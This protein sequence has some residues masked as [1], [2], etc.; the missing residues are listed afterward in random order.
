V[1]NLAFDQRGY[2]AFLYGQMSEFMTAN[3]PRLLLNT[4]VTNISYTNTGVT[5]YSKDGDCIEA[6]YAITTF[7]V[8]V[9]QSGDVSFEPELP[10]WKKIAINT[11]Q[12]GTYTKIY[13][14]FRPEDVFWNATTE[15]FLYASKQRG[16]YPLWQSLDHQNFLS[17][18]GIIFV[19]VVT[20]QSY[21]VDH[22]DDETT[23]QQVLAVLRAMFG[24]DRVPEPIAFMYPRW[25]TTPWAYGSYSNWPP[26]M[27]LENHQN[28]RAN[29]GP[30]YFAGEA[31][32]V[33]FYGYLHGAYFEGKVVGEQ[34]AACITRNC[35]PSVFYETLHGSTAT[36][37]YNFANGWLQADI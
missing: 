25:S 20:E 32:S 33:E 37:Q 3:D 36:E 34:V 10:I 17:R 23:K 7:S 9:L 19:T 14:Q 13:L 26:G 22:Q 8:G 15:L 35:T 1:N 31:T 16:Y 4:I 18:S 6:D 21:V 30:V 5:V 12:M 28:L 2:N 24:N 11:M 29:I 27:T